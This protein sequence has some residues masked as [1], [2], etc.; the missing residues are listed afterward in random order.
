MRDDSGG[1]SV[2]QGVV[3]QGWDWKQELQT[4]HLVALFLAPSLFPSIS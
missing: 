4:P 3:G 2:C 1:L